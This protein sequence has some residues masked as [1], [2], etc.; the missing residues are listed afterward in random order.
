[1]WLTCK[2]AHRLL[3]EAY[4]RPLNTRERLALWIHLKICANCQRFAKQINMMQGQL[5]KWR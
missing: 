5:K 2:Q 3:V 1:M 4:D